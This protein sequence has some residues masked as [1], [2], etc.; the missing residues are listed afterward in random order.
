MELESPSL[1]KELNDTIGYE[2]SKLFEELTGGKTTVIPNE[3]YGNHY[4]A[5]WGEGDEQ[6]LI[7]A[8]FEVL[9]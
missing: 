5:E 2:I 8:H 7:L 1:D 9:C 4:R 3:I 6:I